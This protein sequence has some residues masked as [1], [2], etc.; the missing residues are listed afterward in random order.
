MG[1]VI[2]SIGFECI[3]RLETVLLK[4]LYL[5]PFPIHK[6]PA[7][8]VPHQFNVT[9]M[10][11]VYLLSRLV[12]L[13]RQ[14]AQLCRYAR[15]HA[16]SCHL[17]RQVCH[18]YLVAD[19]HLYSGVALEVTHVSAVAV[20]RKLRICVKTNERRVCA[21]LCFVHHRQCVYRSAR[22]V[23]NDTALV[24]GIGVCVRVCCAQ[25]CSRSC[26]RCTVGV[27]CVCVINAARLHALYILRKDAH[28]FIYHVRLEQI[29]VAPL[30]CKLRNRPAALAYLRTAC[31]YSLVRLLRCQHDVGS[32]RVCSHRFRQVL[33]IAHHVA[34]L[35]IAC[36]LQ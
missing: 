20:L 10:Q 26:C 21:H 13:L 35:G 18:A 7:V 22:L 28:A 12:L 23:S 30:R 25:I 9:S 36:Q 34:H 2:H 1:V 31:R 17:H 14:V 15:Q 6:A 11:L 5:Y 16:V 3:F 27:V 29:Y 19:Y 24:L 32:V 4:S 33:H 8:C